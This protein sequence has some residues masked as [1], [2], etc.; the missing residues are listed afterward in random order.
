MYMGWNIFEET[1]HMRIAL[2]AKELMEKCRAEHWE[3]ELEMIIQL[4]LTAEL[5]LSCEI[6]SQNA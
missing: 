6:F 5:E 2:L 4:L 1:T 3:D